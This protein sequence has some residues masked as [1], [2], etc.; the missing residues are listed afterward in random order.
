M[1]FWLDIQQSLQD[2]ISED[3]FLTWIKPLNFVEFKESEYLLLSAH[4]SVIRDHVL[5]EFKR[6]F[7]RA[8]EELNQA[9]LNLKIRVE[10]VQKEGGNILKA[11]GSL[12][13]SRVGLHKMLNRHNIDA[14]VYKK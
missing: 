10:Q 9:S 1:Q 4:N 14:K 6:P 11:A 13:I 2:F 12:G 7:A 5:E 8:F 3:E